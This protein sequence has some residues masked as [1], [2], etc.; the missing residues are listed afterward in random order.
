MKV[1][2]GEWTGKKVR[3]TMGSTV[4][5]VMEGKLLRVTEE[6]LLLSQHVGRIFIPVYAIL[7]VVEMDSIGG[8]HPDS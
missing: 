8:Q 6:G 4:P 7:H 5:T 3:V 1:M 2:I